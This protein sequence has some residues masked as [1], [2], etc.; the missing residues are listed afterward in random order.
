MS[1]AIPDL[2]D[3]ANASQPALYILDAMGA[4]GALGVFSSWGLALYHWGTHFTGP[5][6]S[7]RRWGVGLTLGMFVG[8]WI[9][10]FTRDSTV[11]SPGTPP[12]GDHG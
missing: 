10:W 12:Q 6:S 8:G 2:R 4:I 1:L 3:A 11:T 9:Y 7:K 5:K